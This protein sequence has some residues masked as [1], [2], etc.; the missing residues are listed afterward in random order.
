M[1]T[2]LRCADTDTLYAFWGPSLTDALNEE[3]DGMAESPAKFVL[4]VASQE[5]A[6]S[7]DLRALRAP[8]IEARFPGP[9]V[10]AKTARGEMARFC[11]TERVDH[12]EQ[13]RGFHG[14]GGW[15][16]VERESTPTTYVFHR[17]AAPA[18]SKAKAAP[19]KAQAASSGGSAAKR[20]KRAS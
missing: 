19:A 3:L 17:G 1:S 2:R 8:V 18:A 11:A 13:L 16:Y 15:A 6:K 9:A 14:S 10:H 7:V 5:Y 12:P 20:R 4:N